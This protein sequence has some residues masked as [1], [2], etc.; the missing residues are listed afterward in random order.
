[1][2]RWKGSEPSS[3]LSQLLK[4]WRALS[5]ERCQTTR[6][7]RTSSEWNKSIRLWRNNRPSLQVWTRYQ[8]VTDA[9]RLLVLHLKAGALVI[10]SLNMY[11]LSRSCRIP[12]DFHAKAFPNTFHRSWFLLSPCGLLELRLGLYRFFHRVYILPSS[13]PSSI[14][15][16]FRLLECVCTEI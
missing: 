12:Y 13:Q 6:V 11:C 2:W 9:Q 3:D 10:C 15:T 8:H 1:M 5:E 14:L 4:C 16:C 7:D